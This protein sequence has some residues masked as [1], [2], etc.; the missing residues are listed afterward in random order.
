M[1]KMFKKIFAIICANLFIFMSLSVYAA[2][3][4][5]KGDI[6]LENQGKDNLKF[7]KLV[8]PTIDEIGRAHV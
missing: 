8:V 3:F 2:P 4:D 6:S 7:D 5:K 1:Y